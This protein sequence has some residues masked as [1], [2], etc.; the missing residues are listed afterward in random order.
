MPA[1]IVYTQASVVL[2]LRAVAGLPMCRTVLLLSASA[3]DTT[4]QTKHNPE[5]TLESRLRGSLLLAESACCMTTPQQTAHCPVCV[6]LSRMYT[7]ERLGENATKFKYAPSEG[8]RSCGGAWV[9][10]AVAVAGAS[11]FGQVCTRACGH[12]DCNLFT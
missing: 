6:R 7:C 3:Q 5:F 2:L 9:R 11:L 10:A 12:I 8:D 4:L 1:L